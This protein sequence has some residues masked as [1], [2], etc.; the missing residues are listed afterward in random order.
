M[1]YEPMQP[2]HYIVDERAFRFWMTDNE[3][4]QA[5]L[6]P[7]EFTVYSRILYRASQQQ[8]SSFESIANIAKATHSSEG[9]VKR[10]LKTLEEKGLIAR[11]ARFRE[12]GRRST[13]LVRILDKTQWRLGASVIHPRITVIPLPDHS[14]PYPPD[15]SDPAELYPIEE[16]NPPELDDHR[17]GS[18]SALGPQATPPKIQPPQPA[19]NPESGK[20]ELSPITHV[21][22]MDPHQHPSAAAKAPTAPSKRPKRLSKEPA[23]S[24]AVWN[25]YV[26]AYGRRYRTPDGRPV[27]P[28]RDQRTNT[29]C[30]TVLDRF[31]HDEALALMHMFLRSNDKFYVRSQHALEAMNDSAW[32]AL[33]TQML[34]GK[35][36][37]SRDAATIEKDAGIQTQYD[38]AMARIDAKYSQNAGTKDKGNPFDV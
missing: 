5:N 34:T 24:S 22:P 23:P 32:K 4:W 35:V 33:R 2:E 7:I 1:G 29:I 3:V 12:D 30:K 27:V 8:R 6:T 14:D 17:S 31:G 36:L 16:L 20:S 21:L 37:T 38:R 19:K 25:A 15:H 10:A 11:E 18:P 13:S 9:S 26:E 28:T